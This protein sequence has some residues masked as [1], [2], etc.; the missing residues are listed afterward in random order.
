MEFIQSSWKAVIALVGSFALTQLPLLQQWVENWVGGLIASV[1]LAASV[2]LKA[3][4]T[5]DA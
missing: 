4:A 5:P 1:F 3:N 2:W